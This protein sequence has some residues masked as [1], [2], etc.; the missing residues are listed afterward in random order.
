MKKSFMKNSMINLMSK[1]VLMSLIIGFG[2]A[3]CKDYLNVIPTSVVSNLTTWTSTANADLFLNAIY[4][5]VPDQTN[6]IEDEEYYSENIMNNYGGTASRTYNLSSYTPSTGIAGWGQIDMWS[7]YKNIRECNV[8]IANVTASNLDDSWKT[9]RVAEAQYLRAYFYYLLYTHFGG[10]PIITDVLDITTQGDAI[11]RARNTPE[12][13]FQFI[14]AEC[15]AA[16]NDLPATTTDF[17]RATKGAALTLKGVC[18]LFHASPLYNT[19]NDL[20]QWALAASTCKEVM[21]LSVYSLFPN[22]ATLF[23]E[24]NNN[25][26]EE[27]F[28]KGAKGGTSL[29]GSREGLRGPQALNGIQL[30]YGCENPT[31]EIVD[32]YFMANGL[33]I[34]DPASG[35]DPQNPYVNRE[36]RFYNDIVYNGGTWGVNT[37]Y[38]YDG[39]QTATDLSDANANSNTG[40]WFKKGLN[41]KWWQNGSNMLSSANWVIFR[42]AEVLLSYAEAQNEAIGPDASVYSAINAIR[43]RS[44][45]PDLQAGLTQDQMRIAIRH[46]RTVELAFETKHW[47]DIIRWK[48]A[49]TVLNGTVHAMEISVVNGINVYTVVPAAAGTRIFYANKNY[50]FPIPQ[51]AIDQN[52]KLVQNPNY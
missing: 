30:S 2:L 14:D 12:E 20:S 19:A 35:Y 18:E 37:F 6:T 31:Q 36:S 42:Y 41:P 33:P 5:S 1:I 47:L 13:T 29:G 16:A 39:S 46:E 15:I 11:F 10:V 17:G 52:S 27:I 34:T 21:D 3:S 8:F 4:G 50:V 23:F 40:Y 51:A 22:L 7:Y 43:E 28:Y 44:Q 48:T 49:E 24:E 32:Q 26:S 45:L 25:N 9:L 38:F